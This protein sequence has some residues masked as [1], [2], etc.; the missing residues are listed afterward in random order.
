MRASLMGSSLLAVPSNTPAPTADLARIQ[1]YPGRAGNTADARKALN[2]LLK[3]PVEAA[4][5][6][7]GA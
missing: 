4:A 6:A 7:L 1:A 2:Y 3:L 5:A